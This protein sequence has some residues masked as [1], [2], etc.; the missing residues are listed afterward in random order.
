MTDIK[1]DPSVQNTGELKTRRRKRRDLA[2]I[3]CAALL[4]GVIGGLVATND[5]GT[6]SL[7][8]G[9]WDKLVF[10]PGVSI[11]LAIALALALIALPL[12]CFTLVD[13][14]VREQNLVGFT[15]GA[16]A[17]L[18]LTPV[19]AV[20]HAGGFLPMPTAAGIWLLTFIASM[21]TF[22]FVWLRDR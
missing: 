12:W 21:A 18:G 7:F 8:D 6:G 2:I 1:A 17:V 14:L 4:G 13:E 22:G 9:S 20:L 3:T 19:W 16:V 10:D 5:K 11:A 15:G